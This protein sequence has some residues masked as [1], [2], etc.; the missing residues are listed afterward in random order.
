MG[1]MRISMIRVDLTLINVRQRDVVT[2]QKRKAVIIILKIER[3]AHTGAA[4]G[5]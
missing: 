1:L 5:Q 4:A 3:F 2:E